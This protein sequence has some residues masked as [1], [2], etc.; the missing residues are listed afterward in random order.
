M[1]VD[2][3]RA[4]L[5][6]LTILRDIPPIPV[7]ELVPCVCYFIDEL[8]LLLGLEGLIATEKRIGYDANEAWTGE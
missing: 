8:D 3:A 2:T 4:E 6:G 7:V 5:I 1:H